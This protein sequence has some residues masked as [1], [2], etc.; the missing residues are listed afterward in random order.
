MRQ[1]P[2]DRRPGV[3]GTA[4]SAP[5]SA[6]SWRRPDHPGQGVAGPG[7]RTAGWPAAAVLAVLAGAAVRVWAVSGS[8]SELN[9]DEA[10]EGLIAI[11]LLHSGELPA[12]FWGQW[13]GGTAEAVAVAGVMRLVGE[14]A[15]AMQL[16]QLAEGLLQAVLVWRIGLRL[17]DPRRAVLAGLLVWAW[18]AAF[19]L[20][21]ARPYL[22][23]ELTIVSGLLVLLLALRVADR[24]AGRAGWAVLGLAAGVAFWSSPQSLYYLL[25]AG[26]WLLARLR[27]V[28]LRRCWPAVPA[29]VLGAAPWLLTNML[30]GWRSLR[31]NEV[32]DG[33]LDRLSALAHTGLPTS[34]GLKVPVGQQ[35]L[36]PGAQLLYVLACLGLA[37]AVRPALRRRS[38]HLLV[39]ATFP[40]VYAL[41][42]VLAEATNGRYFVFL[43]AP[44]AL[45]LAS[46][47]W[48][49]AAA[50]ALLLGC[51]VLT[52][53]GVE[54]TPES[55]RR[56]PPTAAV[57][58]LLSARGVPYAYAGYWTSYKLTWESREAVVATPMTFV[59]YRPYDRAVAAAPRVGLVY[60]AWPDEQAAAAAMRAWLRATGTAYEE[61]QVAGYTVLLP[62]RDLDRG[63]IPATAAVD[64]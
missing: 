64:P 34:L 21:Q 1:F 15:L 38:L 41:V 36:G 61:Q 28:A 6:G 37:F 31:T 14:N 26:L 35:W 12:F 59:R 9:S 60:N 13:Y 50:A 58:A 4:A 45:A 3:T 53:V 10:I 32:P 8:G 44:L 47:A 48:G 43:G 33:P 52:V 25:P 23:Y 16:V 46:V 42:P 55:P 40:V 57:S 22:F 17:L 62:D 27:R 39:L 56:L 30:H 20:L 24:P 7:R 19:V 11:H 54:R 49:R 29:A 2:D 51:T 63:Q 18:P 5:L